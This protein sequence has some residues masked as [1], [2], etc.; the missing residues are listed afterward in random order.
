MSHLLEPSRPVH[1]LRDS[2]ETMDEHPDAVTEVWLQH[3][4]YLIDVAFR[5]L[6][7]IHDAEDVVQDAFGRLLRNGLESIDD[8]RGW[9][10]VVVSRLCLD[11]LRSAHSRRETNAPHID[12]RA[13][14]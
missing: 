13:A 3:R 9:L 10:V 1:V 7:N 4:P 6:G 5:M 12:E 8:I 11:Q 14:Q 2:G